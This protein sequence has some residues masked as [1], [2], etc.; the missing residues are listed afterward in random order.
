MKR[1]A[2]IF[3]GAC[4]ATAAG[5]MA[6]R[7]S[8]R[9]SEIFLP[10]DLERQVPSTFAGWRIDPNIVPVLPDPSLQANLDKIYAQ[11]LARTY[12]NA[13]NQRV[14]LSIA[15]GGD[16]GSDATSAHRPEFCYTAQ[17]FT[18]RP[19]G[20]AQLEFDKHRLVVDR[21]IGRMGARFEPITYWMTLNDQAVLPGLS[22]KLAQMRV[23]LGGLIP[24]GMLVRASTVGLAEQA[25]FQTQTAFLADLYASMPAESRVRY[26][27]G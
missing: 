19:A 8:R 24:D 15:Y 5:A 23:G 16:Q 4:A 6:L 25:A 11:T 7:P 27:G 14:M 21:L 3:A 10:I 9:A 12:V 18:V 2:V 22:R 17:G 20:R 1:R 26:F 13:S